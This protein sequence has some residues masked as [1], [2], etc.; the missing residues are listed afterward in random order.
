MKFALHV[1]RDLL[2]F[3]TRKTLIFTVLLFGLTVCFSA[4][5]YLHGESLAGYK[6]LDGIHWNLRHYVMYFNDS[7]LESIAEF[8]DCELCSKESL[9]A[10]SR[11]YAHTYIHDG[12][13]ILTGYY[14]NSL[15]YVLETGK[16]FNSATN[17]DK[18]VLLANCLI[19][20]EKLMNISDATF[21]I[22]GQP[23]DVIGTGAFPVL[24]PV[25]G[26]PEI[27]NERNVILP[28]EEYKKIAESCATV[29]LYFES[30]LTDSQM[31][32]IIDSFYSR[33]PEES[34]SLPTPS[35]TRNLYEI[36]LLL[37]LI[38]LG[39]GLSLVNVFSFYK[40]WTDYNTKKHYIYMVCGCKNLWLY[41]HIVIQASVIA[42]L[43][44]GL[45][46]LFYYLI[47]PLLAPLGYLYYKIDL[48]NVFVLYLC[49]LALTYVFAHSIAC[50]VSKSVKA[51]RQ[52]LAQD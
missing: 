52:A 38:V 21:F 26:S 39:A 46:L 16:D 43:S 18:P 1:L 25:Q 10:I 47:M 2:Q 31:E 20:P 3:A 15:G 41:F 30:V 19:D 12:D 6:E 28:W 44:F 48:I 50:K 37:A 24:S 34:I 27:V 32:Q 14:G 8:I 13:Y 23:Y 9:P 5:I 4:L 36:Y 22:L 29:D 33:F 42:S 17:T 7:K 51:L 35:E 11:L 40:Y 45:G 49:C